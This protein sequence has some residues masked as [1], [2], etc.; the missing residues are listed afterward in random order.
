[1][2]VTHKLNMDLVRR[3]IT[4]VINAVQTDTYCRKVEITV[5]AGGVAVEF[6][7]DVTV[8]GSYRKA[9][10]TRGIYDTMPDGVTKAGSVAGNV[11]TLS[12]APQ[13]L[14]AAGTAEL[15]VQLI[16]GETLLNVFPIQVDVAPLPGFGGKS[17]N[18]YSVS[19]LPQITA[20]D[21]GKVLTVVDG[22]W[23]AGAAVAGSGITSIEKNLILSLFR[24]IVYTSADM[25]VVYAQLEALW[26]GS[27]DDSGG[28]ETETTLSRISATYSGGDVA[29]GTAVTGLTG[30]VVTAHYSDGS[31]AILTGYTL[32]GN[33]AE[34][35]NT[36]TV[37]YSGKTTTFA[38]TGVAES[39]GGNEK[40]I[41]F[42]AVVAGSRSTSETGALI[43][44]NNIPYQAITIPTGVYLENGRSYVVSLG[45]LVP[46]DDAGAC[47]YRMAV[48]TYD[49][50]AP[51]RVFELPAE[52]DTITYDNTLVLVASGW[53]A[54][55]FDFASTVDNEILIVIFKRTD[56][57]D[58]SAEDCNAI[59]ENLTV[60]EV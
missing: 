5:A 45:S 53:R 36:V 57:A 11:V 25:G 43:L 9:D 12:L 7:E 59:F 47:A 27:A 29:V 4:E 30:V 22:M 46:V 10:G 50:N 41:E 34:G 58:M 60:K 40:S 39:S 13:L 49:V 26:S 3:G 24:N 33:I 8:R 54:S 56:G 6:P 31:T 28:T 1:M 35:R 32:M 42:A 37:Y 15:A 18:Y 17:E 2:I 19:G 20:A 48:G 51:G 38:V 16:S 23:V 44:K 55:D 14:T 21:N 52:G